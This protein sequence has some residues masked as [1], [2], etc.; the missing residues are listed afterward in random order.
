[1]I[2]IARIPNNSWRNRSRKIIPNDVM[3]YFSMCL[4]RTHFMVEFEISSRDV[5]NSF[6]Y[7]EA[8][9]IAIMITLNKLLLL[10]NNL[11]AVMILA[12]K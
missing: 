3:Y 4:L 1:M 2:R 5:N 11:N 12:M 6:C 10:I 8:V 9:I 7:H